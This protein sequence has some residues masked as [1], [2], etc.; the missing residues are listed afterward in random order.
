MHTINL[1]GKGCI[2]QVDCESTLGTAVFENIV[3]RNEKKHSHSKFSYNCSDLQ[4]KQIAIQEDN[5]INTYS[6]FCLVVLVVEPLLL[7]SFV[8]L[9]FCIFISNQSAKKKKRKKISHTFL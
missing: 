6:L 5:N 7:V 9:P 1:V 3:I 2:M 4:L 8:S